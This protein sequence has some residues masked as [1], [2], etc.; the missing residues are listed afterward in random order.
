MCCA[1]RYF[2]ALKTGQVAGSMFEQRN[3]L[4]GDEPVEGTSG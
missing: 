4:P 2:K 1:E 3:Y